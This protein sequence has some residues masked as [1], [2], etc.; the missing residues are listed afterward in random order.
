MSYEQQFIERLQQQ[1]RAMQFHD[2]PLVIEL[3]GE[4]AWK[5]WDCAVREIDAKQVEADHA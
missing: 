2:L 4:P 3:E 5:A 1:S